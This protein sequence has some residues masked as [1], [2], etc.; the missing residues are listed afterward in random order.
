MTDPMLWS[1][2]VRLVRM[3]AP[4]FAVACAVWLWFAPTKT[5]FIVPERTLVDLALGPGS[6]HEE[7]DEEWK[8][9]GID[10]DITYVLELP[11]KSASFV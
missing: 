1:R 5:T 6:E 9:S 10:V 7:P 4:V 11:R 2:Q 3:G 8:P